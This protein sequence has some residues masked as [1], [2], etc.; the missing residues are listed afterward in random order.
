MANPKEKSEPKIKT[1]ASGKLVGPGMF[2][3]VR[4]RPEPHP[5]EEIIAGNQQSPSDPVP[6]VK[7]EPLMKIEPGA[8]SEPLAEIEPLSKSVPVP[9]F[10]RGTPLLSHRPPLQPEPVAD[11]EPVIISEGVTILPANAPHLRFPY[12]VLDKV[13]PTLKPGPRA[14]CERLYRLSAGFDTD[15]CVV[16]IGKLASS[17]NIGETQIRQY[18]RELETKRLIRRL[19]DDIA[20]RNLEARGI[21][22]KV[23]LPRMPPARNRTGSESGRGSVSEPIKVN[24]QK[25]NTQTQNVV[26]VNSPFSLEEC[27]RYANH[28]KQTGQGITNPG[29]YATKIFRSGEADA[30]IEAF[31]NPQAPLDISQ[32]LDCRG[33]NF[34]YIDPSNHDKGVRPCKHEALKGSTH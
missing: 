28:L 12:E 27:R 3:R 23:L 16:S 15:E 31:L 21:K 20:N 17:C 11:P 6:A 8:G 29:G 9:E 4:L 33:S 7:S 22:F 14:V 5:I 19:G 34:I 25:E 18:L 13:L 26:S 24:T 10:V 1:R 2:D 32:C 30:F